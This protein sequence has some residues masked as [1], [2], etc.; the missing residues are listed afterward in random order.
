MSSFFFNISARNSIL[1]SGLEY[2]YFPD[3]TDFVYFIRTQSEAINIYSIIS[4]SVFAARLEL[5]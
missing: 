4:E 1:F 2:E 5:P 3:D